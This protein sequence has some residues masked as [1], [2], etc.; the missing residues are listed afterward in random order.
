MTQASGKRMTI[1]LRKLDQE[2]LERIVELLGDSSD[3]EAIRTSL[4]LMATVLE[5]QKSGGKIGL[6]KEGKTEYVRFL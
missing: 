2:N 6:Q 5:W 4:S 3:V 1:T